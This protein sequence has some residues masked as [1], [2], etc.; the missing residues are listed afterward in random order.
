MKTQIK[1]FFTQFSAVLLFAILIAGCAKE[2]VAT[3]SEQDDFL[4]ELITSL[5]DA[6][7]ME[8]GIELRSKYKRSTFYTLRAAL[9]CT[10]LSGVMK[11]RDLTLFAPDDAAFAKLGL[12]K[13]NICD[14]FDTETLTNILTY[15]VFGERILVVR[16][17]SLTMFNGA[18]ANIISKPISIRGDYYK[19][20]LINGSR[21]IGRGKCRGIKTFVIN[22]VILP[23]SSNIVEAAQATDKFSVLVQAILAADPGVEEALSAPGAGVTVFA[24]TNQ[25]FF[26]LLAALNLASLDDVVAALG[27][28]G[29]TKVLQ[30]HVVPAVA[31]STDLVD[32]AEL[33]T[34]QGETIMVDLENLQLG[35]KSG[36]PTGLVAD[37]LDI[38]ASNGI[39]HTI[40]RILLPQ[41]ILDA[42]GL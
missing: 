10:G 1:T 24:P 14:A 2:D 16:P 34:L 36:A 4:N 29:L 42:L 37:C 9:K 22:N 6:E 19:R 7:S 30:Y 28:E 13:N 41:E 3:V 27:V 33:P 5:E 31:Y 17:G 8:E 38:V 40:D 11:N 21:L 25:A 32:G 18:P 39:V 26:D 12:D 15:H 20:Y 23:P 35:D